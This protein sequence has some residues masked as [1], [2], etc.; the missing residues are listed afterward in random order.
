MVAFKTS[1][2]NQWFLDSFKMQAMTIGQNV[3]YNL[4][5]MSCEWRGH[6]VNNLRCNRLVVI[7]GNGFWKL[8]GFF[9]HD[10]FTCKLAQF[11]LLI[12]RQ[13]FRIQIFKKKGKKN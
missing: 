7:E 5:Y 8:T 2:N 4:W 6:M 13:Q 9:K 1:I 11:T 3:Y 10:H 12:R